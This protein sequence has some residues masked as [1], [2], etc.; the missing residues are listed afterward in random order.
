MKIVSAFQEYWTDFV[1]ILPDITIGIIFLI[2]GVLFV[3]F[4]AGL[5][6]RILS[7]VGLDKLS[8]TIGM[9]RMLGSMGITTPLSKMISMILYYM[10]LM[11]VVMLA[12]EQM[13]IAAL[14]TAIS[15]ILAYIPKLLT[16]ILIFMIGALIG[17]KIK[18]A[19]ATIT[20]TL[21]VKGG[22]VIAQI[23]YVVIMLIVIITALNMAGIDTSLL[24]S[25]ILV[26]MGS[27]L[28][29]FGVAYGF[30]SKDI[31]QNIL[32]SYYGRDRL[33]KGMRIRLGQDEGVIER[34]DSISVYIDC[35]DKKVM[36]PC[37]KLISERIEILEEV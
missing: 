15:G 17:D 5:V 8:K 7:K 32:S 16:A 6:R 20:E 23:V 1:Q 28:L 29:A 14:T 34:I 19:I 21:G 11:F 24:T 13:N 10:L 3:K 9:E 22:R 4:I 2:I 26:I 36:I 12:A 35:G 27:I 31:L 18:E 30:A 33:K 37:N 25:N